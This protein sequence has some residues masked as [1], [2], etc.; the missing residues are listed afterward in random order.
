MTGSK[1]V[2]MQPNLKRIQYRVRGQVQGVGFRPFVYQLAWDLGLTGWVLN[3]QE[4]VLIEVQGSTTNAFLNALHKQAP[5][6]SRIQS[7]EEKEI[8]KKENEAVFLIR[9]SEC[10]DVQTDII[11]DAAICPDCLSEMR[12]P[13]DRRY[14]YPFLNCTHCGPRYTITHS[15]PYDRAQ[16]SM[17]A[18]EMC[19]A[20]EAEYRD[21][22]NR[23]FHAQPTCCPNCGPRLSM[24]ISEIANRIRQGQILAIKGLGGFHLVCDAHNETAIEKLRKRKN[25]DAKPFAIMVADCQAICDFAKL[26]QNEQIL[27][28]SPERPIVLLRKKKSNLPDT[29]APNLN[30]IGVMLPYTP[31]H[32]LIMDALR[33]RPLV[34][35]S[36]N[37]GGEPLVIA[38]DEA[39]HRLSNIADAIVTHNRDILIR[40]D[41]SV[42][43]H[44]L[45][46]PTVL[47]SA[48]GFTPRPIDLTQDTPSILG[49]GAFLKNTICLTRA[50]HAYLS[51]HIGDLDNVATLRF[52]EETFDHLRK[53][54]HVDPV[55]AVHDLHPD[56]ASTRFAH[57]L[58]IETFAVQHHHAHIASVLAEHQIEG[59]VIG[60]ALDGFGLGDNGESWGGE[61]FKVDG[62]NCT[63]IGH[64]RPLTQPGG[65]KAAVEPWRM[66]ASALHALGRRDE[67]DS[68]FAGHDTQTLKLML[69]KGLN[70][71]H[72]SSMG[73]LF[74]AACGLLGICETTQ[75]EGHAPMMLESLV[76][77]IEVDPQGWQLDENGELNLL[78][79]LNTLCERTAQ[80]GANLFHG[81][82]VFALADWV[83]QACTK[84][85]ISRVALSGGCF[86]NEILSQ[87]L[88]RK[89]QQAGLKVYLNQHVPL[90]DAGLSLGQAWLGQQK[91]LRDGS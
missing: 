72:T 43:R 91:L 7:I 89:L 76:S 4:G 33:G 79:L 16:T 13:N 42:V 68:R 25:R 61:L 78:A 5:A 62:L 81:T 40:V 10:G 47:R 74:D 58:G 64:L 30:R 59:P 1:P 8:E 35:T 18:F 12:D 54:L 48:R 14:G 32:Y 55:L 57:R 66:G 86:L 21:P 37:P 22:V 23:R 26:D 82:L 56:F 60:L 45:S 27:L 36:A 11:P 75:Y 41:D 19:P 87:G 29:I 15:L 69:D 50:N 39:E 28:E 52:Q 80:S 63:R 46:G 3:D 83:E 77:R 6:L 38:N 88:K 90:S 51:Q 20:C 2:L 34:M 70:S 71:P 73:R 65:D 49:L 67:I 85:N 31:L 44:D 17:A 9:E 53:I 84:H 24:D